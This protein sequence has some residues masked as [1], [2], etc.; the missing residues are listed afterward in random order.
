[1]VEASG[2][3]YAKKVMPSAGIGAPSGGEGDS[4]E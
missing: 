1:V 3:R 4:G 2:A